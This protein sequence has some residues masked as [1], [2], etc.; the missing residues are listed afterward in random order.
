[1]YR[2]NAATVMQGERQDR[3]VM[4]CQSPMIT[5]IVFDWLASKPKI[6]KVQRE[7][8]DEDQPEEERPAS[9]RG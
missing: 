1:M 7:H 8:L 6:G 2:E 9:R 5:H 3:Q 4:E